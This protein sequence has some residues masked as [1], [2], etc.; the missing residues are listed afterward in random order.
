MEETA[1]EW[2]ARQELAALANFYAAGGEVDY[3]D[4]SC[5]SSN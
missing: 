5:V 3:L 2:S 1:G 4:L